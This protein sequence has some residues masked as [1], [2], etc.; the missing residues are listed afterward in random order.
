[1]KRCDYWEER[2]IHRDW[3]L[4]PNEKAPEYRE[5]RV[6]GPTK[7]VDGRERQREHEEGM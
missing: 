5:I 7:A 1:V 2:H 6:S 4:K 3:T